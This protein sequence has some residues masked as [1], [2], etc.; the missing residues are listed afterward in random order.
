LFAHVL[1]LVLDGVV[2]LQV[3]P[4]K[5]YLQSRGLGSD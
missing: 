5:P 2:Q 1:C 4:S 3:R